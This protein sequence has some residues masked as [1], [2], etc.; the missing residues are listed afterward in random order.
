MKMLADHL[1]V[2]PRDVRAVDVENDLSEL[3]ALNGYVVGAHVLDGVRQ[4]VSGW[5]DRPRVRAWSVTGPYGAGKSAFAHLLASLHGP[6]G[7]P[8]RHRAWQLMSA[9]DAQLTQTVSSELDRLNAS[10][11]GFLTAA[12][13]AQRESVANAVVRALCAAAERRWAKGRAPAV[14]KELRGARDAGV[15]SDGAGEVVLRWIE[16]LSREAPVL[17]IVDELGKTLEHA[18]ARP[19][20]T[21]LFLLQQIAEHFTSQH[22]CAGGL[23]TL[24]HLAFEDYLTGVSEARRREWRKVQGRFAD[25]PFIADADHGHRLVAAALDYR[26]QSTL[27][28]R[29]DVAA[30]RAEHAIADVA[31]EA[32]L[33]SSAT[34]HPGATYPLHPAAAVALPELA[35]RYG[36]HDRT[37]VAFLAGRAPTAMPAFLAKTPVDTDGEP[38]FL[39]LHHLYDAFID[40]PEAGQAPGSDG[41]RLREVRTRLNDAIG[42]D[43]VAL[44]CAKTVAVLNLVATQ[45]GLRADPAVIEESLVGPGGSAADRT[46]VREALDA[47]VASGLLVWRNFAGEYRVWWGSDVDIEAHVVAERERIASGHSSDDLLTMLAEIRPLRAQVARRHSLEHEVLRY[48]DCRYSLAVAE[49]VSCTTDTADGLVLIVLGDDALGSV[50]A[51]TADG[52]PLIVIHTAHGREVLDAALDAAATSRVLQSE[53]AVAN[54]PVARGEVRH[55]TAMAQAAVA[56]RLDSAL[57]HTRDDVHWVFAGEM[58]PAGTPAEFSRRLSVLCDRRYP[59]TPVIRNE[60][61]NR[62]ELTSQGAKA[63]GELLRRM[64]EQRHDERLGIEGY[65]PERAMYEAVLFHTGLHRPAGDAWD[66][67]PPEDAGVAGAYETIVAFFESATADPRPI[68]ELYTQLMA[69]PLGM[70]DGAIPILLAAALLHRDDDVFLYQDGTFMPEVG[71]PDLERLLKSPNRFAV[72]RAA[73]LQGQAKVFRALRSLLSGDA[74]AGKRERNR[75]TLAIV[76][77]LLVR[78]R[79]LPDYTK[80]TAHLS[81]TARAVRD[82][83]AQAREPDALLLQNLPRACGLPPFASK[84]VTSAEAEKFVAALRAALVELEQA[85][86]VLLARIETLLRSA[87]AV[88]RG[89]KSVREDL[90]A[91]SMHLVDQVIDPR[92]RG[93]LAAACNA[94]NSHSEWLESLAMNVAVTPVGSWSDRDADVFESQ[95]ADR[96]RW[97]ARLEALHAELAGSSPTGFT[98]RRVTVTSPQGQ[99]SA[100]VVTLDDRHRARINEDLD[101]L[102]E[103]IRSNEDHPEQA[104]LAVLADR[105]LAAEYVQQDRPQLRAVEK[106]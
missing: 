38:S 18:H 89:Q 52:R 5:Q 105:L 71:A 8:L 62:R 17:L 20:D 54:D 65:G 30:D 1:L 92:T 26:S 95:L 45:R 60:M 66:F 97:F 10:Q 21:D 35:A 41:A 74:P 23:L 7:S 22:T 40:D 46:Q 79:E 73:H 94:A 43:G 76:R 34:R 15:A 106:Q 53:P 37:L 56:E 85:Y 63:R 80:Q 31:G 81:H 90:R 96:A 25:L 36:Q 69:P 57:D 27:R 16:R 33:P 87:F 14:L 51:G 11:S 75:T 70:K 39:R 12:V 68:D 50:P 99:E 78:W 101:A 77:P 67:L 47:L 24:Q 42:L 59:S 104:L 3:E 13:R 2:R 4:V 103:S 55:R 88:P 93:F 64:F 28:E 61:L 48:F 84:L 82:A 58:G 98:S 6:A 19:E 32:R 72:K 44:A 83:L 49:D 91:R 9:A 29:A 102:L 86:D 100:R